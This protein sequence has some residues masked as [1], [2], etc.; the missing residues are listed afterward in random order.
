MISPTTLPAARL[1]FAAA[2]P[3]V[4]ALA[5]VPRPH[6]AETRSRPRVTRAGAVG[7]LGP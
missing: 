7:I 2:A 5:E 1:G 6:L 4:A 3:N